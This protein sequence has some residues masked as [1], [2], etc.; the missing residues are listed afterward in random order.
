MFHNLKVDATRAF[1]FMEIAIGICFGMV[2]ATNSL[3]EATVAGLTALQLVLIGTTLEVSTF[4]FEVPTGIVADVYSR[5]LSIIIGHLLIGLGFLIEGFFPAFGPIVIANVI[6]GLGY[7]FTSG[8]KQA[9]ITDEV[10][11]EAANKLF[12]RTARLGAVAWL[13]TLG[14]TAWIGAENI[15]IPI[16]VGAIGIILGGIVLAFIMP[17]TGF[18]PTPREDRNT[19]QHMWH[20]FRQGA[21]AVRA[22]PRLGNIVFIGL[23]YGLY[24]EGVDRLSVKLLLDNFDLPVLFGSNQLPFFMLLDVIGAVLYIFVIRQVEKRIDTSSP[25]AIGRAMLLITGLITLS[26]LSF[27]LSPVLVLA[28]I[29]MIAVGL[30][31]GVSGPL[32]ITWVNQKLDSRVR[33]TIHSMFGQ[34]DAIGQAMGGPIIGTVANLYTV[35]MAV[36]FASFLLAPALLFIQRANQI[37]VADVE[38]TEALSEPTL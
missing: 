25:L 22:H 37:P 4:L 27:A 15:A 36:S 26:L 7:T 33:A 35:R 29:S 3:Y 8:A 12:L 24:S 18:H 10:G 5:R 21:G 2:V 1:L 9:W 23:F 31:R 30:L 11:E 28:V 19:W 16:R 13:L 14:I 38:T 17:E 34:V 32:R 20:V 6:W